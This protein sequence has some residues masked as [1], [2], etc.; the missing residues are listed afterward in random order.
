MSALLI[1]LGAALGA[2][3]RFLVDRTVRARSSGLVPWG[4][5]A[6]NVA[7]ALVL[8]LL[9]GLSVQHRLSA[10]WLLLLG[11][12]F[13]GALTTF[14]TF[15]YD[16]IAI[17]ERRQWVAGVVTLAVHLVVALPAA[18]LGWVLSGASW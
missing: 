10:D 1:A 2:P 18:A 5:V 13:C 17:L 11:T 15:A 3:T 9:T 12:G 6:V 16:V 14:S 4:I 7:G 8:G